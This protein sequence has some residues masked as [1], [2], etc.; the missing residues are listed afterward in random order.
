MKRSIAIITAKLIKKLSQLS[1]KGG[2]NLPGE[3]ARRIDKNILKK[4]RQNV[5]QV[6]FITGT[7]GKTTTSTLLGH[8]L[9][10]KHKIVWNQEGSNL[11]TGITTA[12]IDQ[13]PIIGKK[14]INYAVIEIDEGSIPQV[15]NEITPDYLLGLNLF[16]DQIDRYG[17]PAELSTRLKNILHDKGIH[18]I[19][20]A[21]DP[22]IAQWGMDEKSTYYGLSEA[23]H[24]NKFFVKEGSLD[25]LQCNDGKLAYQTHF[26]AH[27]GVYACN[28]CDFKTPKLDYK[29]QNIYTSHPLH[30]YINHQSYQVD[31]SGKFNA[32]NLLAAVSLCDM[33][34]LSTTDIQSGLDLVKAPTGRMEQFNIN[35]KDI[36]FNLSKNA[37]GVNET[38]KAMPQNE[39]DKLLCLIFENKA[40]D[41]LDDSWVE[42][43]DYSMLETLNIKHVLLA[44]ALKDK[45]KQA[46]PE[47]ITST[48][49]V[50]F[51]NE[52][53]DIVEKALTSD[54]KEIIMIP[55]YTAMGPIRQAILNQKKLMQN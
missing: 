12:F 1:G 45:V 17:S 33:I 49:K 46:L 55:N 3:F 27:H 38:F 20:N 9:G 8:I 37:V 53:T 16:P 18:F 36:L 48:V 4:L 23:I 15:L 54:Y 35:G 19:L 29:L 52:R 40:H 31:L 34:G 42:D 14:K 2:S 6:I 50:D 26:G 51:I 13:Q 41:G 25:C 21:N 47:G 28:R 30:I 43:I 11:I 5:N 7:N 32:Y 39:N 10:R 22:Y 24:N 44:G